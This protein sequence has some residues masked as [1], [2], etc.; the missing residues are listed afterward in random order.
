MVS[1]RTLVLSASNVAEV[2]PPV[3]IYLS[4]LVAI[5]G[6]LAYAL[7]ANPKMQEIGRISYFAGLLAFLLET[8][9]YVEALPK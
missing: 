9:H 6:L 8:V 5:I 2:N 1:N 7:S 4:L 3:I